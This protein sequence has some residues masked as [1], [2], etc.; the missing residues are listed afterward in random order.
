M[1]TI[2][3][4]STPALSQRLRVLCRLGALLLCLMPAASWGD[5]LTGELI[6]RVITTAG[7]VLEAKTGTYGDL[8]P[9]GAELPS[10][11]P[12]MALDVQPQG[13]AAGRLLIPGTG[14]ARL[15]EGPIAIFEPA[16][17]AADETLLLL[18]Q[19]LSSDG[20]VRQIRGIGVR[21]GSAGLEWSE[22]FAV[23]GADGQVLELSAAPQFAITRQ[24][25]SHQIEAESIHVRHTLVHLLWQGPGGTA[26]YSAVVWVNGLYVGHN[27]VFD[28]S[29]EYLVASEGDGATETLPLSAELLQASHLEVAEGGR[30]LRLAFANGTSGR[31]GNLLIEAVPLAHGVLGDLVRQEVFEHADSFD[32]GALQSFVDKFRAGVVII[33]RNYK[34]HPA[35]VEYVSS[36]V[37]N[38]ILDNGESYGYEEFVGLGKDARDLTIGLTQS[39]YASTV[40]DPGA[41]GSTLV[42]LDLSGVFGG[43][44][45]ADH[46]GQ[47][48]GFQVT[49]DLA[50]P[51]IGEGDV[52]LLASNDGQRLLITWL[53]DEGSQLH[54]VESRL[55]GSWSEAQVIALHDGLTSTEAQRLLRSKLQ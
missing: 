17:E 15:E 28:L 8:F 24:D 37:G 6:P 54:Y 3:T 52:A 39:V 9:G 29:A 55:D 23:N 11:T 48:L 38:W 14:D 50:V 1:K 35:V 4:Q 45:A 10:A 46:P 51:Q 25:F 41:P 26:M 21:R 2:P 44:T 22:A 5:S 16:A 30:S 49:A 7:E 32:P 34:Y 36:R 12:V 47:L 40:E 53:D 18:W 13:G 27:P 33:G 43:D 31:I 19:S 42:E 20:A